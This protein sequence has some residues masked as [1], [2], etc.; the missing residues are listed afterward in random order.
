MKAS[1]K[2]PPA[3]MPVLEGPLPEQELDLCSL[4]TAPVLPVIFPEINAVAAPAW[5]GTPPVFAA[6]AAP[7][8]SGSFPRPLMTRTVWYY[9]LVLGGNC[10]MHVPGKALRL[11]RGDML[12][13]SPTCR[14]GYTGQKGRRYYRI[15]WAWRSP[16]LIP[17]IKPEEGQ[18]LMMKLSEQKIKRL[19]F[20]HVA[21]RKILRRLD[22]F[23]QFK[24]HNIR[25]EIDLLLAQTRVTPDVTKTPAMQF[26]LAVRWI[27]EHMMM[28][29]A[30]GALCEYLA[31]SPATLNRLFHRRLKISPAVYLQKLKMKYARTLLQSG[32]LSVK[33]VAYQLGYKHPNDFSYA[34]KHHIGTAPTGQVL[35]QN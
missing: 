7:A 35:R 2:H 13:M 11:K 6:V 10:Y 20:L 15:Y 34:Y 4:S 24:L 16:P 26:A 8:R 12:V 18:Y 31:I 30:I 21:C 23:T 29:D 17:L 33:A 3:P 27:E 25:R 14:R 5:S 1:L 32:N 22:Q 28:R 19:Q 9:T